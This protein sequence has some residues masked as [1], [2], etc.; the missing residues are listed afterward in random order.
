MFLLLKSFTDLPFSGVSS[1]DN[2]L[3]RRC[4]SEKK[5]AFVLCRFGLHAV[6]T[7]LFGFLQKQSVA[8]WLIVFEA[9]KLLVKTV[10]ANE[11]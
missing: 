3:L 1:C 7:C 6:W 8:L 5:V 2:V 11:L 4:L 10:I 9:L